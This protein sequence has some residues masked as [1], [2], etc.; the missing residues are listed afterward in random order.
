MGQQEAVREVVGR[1]E[2]RQVGR[3]GLSGD[4]G[5]A[6]GQA[7]LAV[8]GSRVQVGAVGFVVA[9]RAGGGDG[10]VAEFAG[11]RGVAAGVAEF[12]EFAV[13]S[14]GAQVRVVAQAACG[15]AGE[16]G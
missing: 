14:R 15:V 12:A 6:Q 5:D 7:L 3:D 13:Q 2:A 1:G 10:A 4:R 8:Q 9:G 16:R 11:E